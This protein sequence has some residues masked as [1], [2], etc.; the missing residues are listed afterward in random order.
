MRQTFRTGITKPVAWRRRQLLQLARFAK[1]NA[2]ALAEAI[3][4]DL[5]KPKQ[6]VIMAEVHPVIERSLIAAEKVEEW[7]KPE[8][9]TTQA[10]QQGWNPR[11][12]KHP[13]GVVLIIA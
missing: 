13:K 4:L 6:E 1:E 10:W 3:R 8:P 9:V 12:E 5:G 2:D 11:I 7:V